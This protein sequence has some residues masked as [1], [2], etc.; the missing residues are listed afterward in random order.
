MAFAN[1]QSDATP[2]AHWL[3]SLAL[4]LCVELL[5]VVGLIQWMHAK[6]TDLEVGHEIELSIEKIE[7]A[8]AAPPPPKPQ[9]IA[10]PKQLAQPTVP[11]LPPQV[12]STERTDTPPEPAA[13]PVTVPVRETVA[14]VVTPPVAPAKAPDHSEYMAKVRAAVQQAFVYP[15]AASSLGLHGRVKV[16]FKLNQQTP[17]NA[18]VLVSSGVSMIDRAA[19]ASVMTARYPDP[20]AE[21]NLAQMEFEIWIEYRPS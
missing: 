4:A 15:A 9:P 8:P 7:P 2:M 11:H 16:K 6:P 3:M 14:P 17:V 1:R 20:A 18:Q 21:V 13:K 19:I 5:V 12:T 10:H